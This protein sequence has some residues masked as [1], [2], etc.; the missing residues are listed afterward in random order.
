MEKRVVVVSGGEIKD[1][2]RMRS[3]LRHDDFF[4]YCDSGLRHQKELGVA[5]SL[6]VGD[7]DSHEKPGS[8]IIIELPRE[9]DDTDTIFGVRKAL[10][11]GYREFVLLGMTGGRMD[12]TLANLFILDLLAQHG[13]RGLIVD[14]WCEM[15]RVGSEWKTIPDSFPYFSII[16]WKGR[17][18][19]VDIENAKYPLLNASIDPSYQY[20][21]S[22]EPLKGGAR[23]RVGKGS[24]LLLR[25]TRS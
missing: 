1:Y 14:D 6:V 8:G 16:A 13:A 12:H 23:V 19:G 15:E 4:L 7:F 22:N 2:K 9:K 25:D 17:V 24:A 5:P 21:V 11:M 20:A 3:L 10:D 18:E